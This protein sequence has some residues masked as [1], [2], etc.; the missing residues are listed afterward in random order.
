MHETLPVGRYGIFDG[1]HIIAHDGQTFE[2]PQNSD[3]LDQIRDTH[4]WTFFEL[5]LAPG[6]YYPRMARATVHNLQNKRGQNPGNEQDLT[7]IEVG[8]GQ[9]VVLKQQLEG[10]FRTVHPVERNFLAYGHDIRNLL[11]LA[12]TEVEAHWKGVLKANN[13]S[14]SSTNDYVKLL[15]AMKLDEYALRLPYYPW[16]GP[17]MPFKNWDRSRSTQSLEWYDAYNAVKHNR[18]EE[19]ER[20]TLIHTIEAV[21]ACAIMTFAQFGY[22]GYTYRE[23]IASFFQLETAPTW[24]PEETYDV[25]SRFV[26]GLRPVI[27]QF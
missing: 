26:E 21:C 15:P 18:E 6:E 16:L 5:K 14:G 23:E 9:L 20:G 24:S 27:Y 10:I 8:R 13:S 4:G 22:T 19:F 3:P 17:V 1:V 7:L 12:A 2:V 25:Q 11:I